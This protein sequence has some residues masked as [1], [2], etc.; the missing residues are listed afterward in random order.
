MRRIFLLS[1]FMLIM[2]GVYAQKQFMNGQ[3]AVNNLNVAKT[4]DGKLLISMD[5]DVSNLEVGKNKEV[6]F[7]PELVKD[8][9]KITFPAVTI[10]GKNRYYSHLRNDNGYDP[11]LHR[12]GKLN[13]IQY[14]ASTNYEDWMEDAKLEMNQDVCGCNAK[15]LANDRQELVQ[16]DFVEKP[17]VFEY[18]YIQ[19]KA[20]AV[21]HRSV[22]GSAFIDFPVNKINLYED[23]RENP[24]ELKKILATIDE[25][26]NDPDTKITSITIK[27]YA[28]PEGSYKNNT[29]LAK[30]RTETL[31]SYVKG[32][33]DFPAETYKTD[34]EPEDWE[35]LREYLDSTDLKDKNGIIEIMGKDLTP[36]EMNWS[37]QARYPETY[38]FLLKNVYPALRHSDYKVE[39]EVRQYVTAEEARRVMAENP[40]KL[41]QQEFYLVANSYEM[42]SK[43][44]N[45]AYETMVK[46]YPDDPIA[47]LNAANVALAQEDLNKAESYLNKSGDLKEAVYARGILAHK[48]GNVD[49]A[50]RLFKQALEMGVDQASMYIEK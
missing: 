23:Y 42:G 10:A 37:I 7:A 16:L 25:V 24:R 5:F 19:P 13:A 45:E 44:F 6:S 49:K 17:V 34:Y 4:D 31:K 14:Q 1:I 26:K 48:R 18:A 9:K 29:R 39:Y 43:E 21:K 30:G 35:G 15:L 3:V 36:D 47:N 33:Y 46:I 41:S 40:S 38:R 20:E 2:G 32:L 28:S 8:E 11:L 50:E 27:G 22:E 12:A